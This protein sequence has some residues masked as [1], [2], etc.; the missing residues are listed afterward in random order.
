MSKLIQ[1]LKLFLLRDV[2]RLFRNNTKKKMAFHQDNTPSHVSKKSNYSLNASKVNP[3]RPEEW[4]RK[5]PDAVPMDYSIW[6][7]LKQQP[8][9]QNVETLD[10]PK[11]A[12][13]PMEKAGSNLY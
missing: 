4:M 9:K 3:I 2:P 6:G 12:F 10:K 7:Y 13:I 8:N 11:K 5:L 1:I